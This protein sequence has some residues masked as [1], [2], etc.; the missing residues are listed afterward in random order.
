M[1]R[2]RLN[3]ALIAMVYG[4]ALSLLWLGSHVDIRLVLP[5]GVAYSFV[6]LTNYA[7]IHE[8]AHDN[9]NSDPTRNRWLGVLVGFLF[10]VPFSMIK[11]THTV[12]HCCN[13]TDHEMF[14]LYYPGDR[15]L[16]KLG[17]WYG[18]LA[19]LF[20]PWIPIG[21]LVLAT[22]PQLLRMGPYRRA[23]TTAV[24]FDDFAETGV[25]RVRIEV[26]LTLVF[27]T[28]LFFVLDLSWPAVLI[29]YGFFAFN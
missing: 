16:I 10:P 4:F 20:W 22:F 26:V 1:I 2:N 27:W 25:G 6:L 8:A 28:V 17:Q 13:R 7:L 18:L 3:M 21:A 5:I 24:L 9:L 11:V 15:K 23:R 12:H 29:M 14:D 19:G